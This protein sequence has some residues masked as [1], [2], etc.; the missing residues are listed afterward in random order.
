M[1]I[2][3]LFLILSFLIHSNIFSQNIPDL[4]DLPN[5]NTTSKGAWKIYTPNEEDLWQYRQFHENDENQQEFTDLNISRPVEGTRIYA[6]SS[7]PSVAYDRI[8]YF[9]SNSTHQTPI[10][11][12]KRNHSSMPVK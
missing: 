7:A 1:R 8:P 5:I 11:I 3:F 12:P 10:I 6:Y 9:D 2:S 4:H